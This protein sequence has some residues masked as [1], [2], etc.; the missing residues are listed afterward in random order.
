MPYQLELDNVRFLPDGL[1]LHYG[2]TRNSVTPAGPLHGAGF[3]PAKCPKPTEPQT[4]K[5]GLTCATQKPGTALPASERGSIPGAITRPGIAVAAGNGKQSLK[6]KTRFRDCSETGA[7]AHMHTQRVKCWRSNPGLTKW[8][9][10][11]KDAMTT[12]AAIDRLVHHRSSGSL[13]RIS[14]AFQNFAEPGRIPDG[15]RCTPGAGRA[16]CESGSFAPKDLRLHGLIDLLSCLVP[17]F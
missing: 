8:D 3:Q 10:I 12:A 15:A 13:L 6:D 4:R 16:T 17:E 5:A 14:E 2:L 11:F 9:Q 1:L 7:G